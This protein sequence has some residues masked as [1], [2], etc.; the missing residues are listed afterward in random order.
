MIRTVLLLI[1]LV[2][3]FLVIFGKSPLP[4]DSFLIE[5]VVAVLFTVITTITAWFKN[6]YV[7]K[8]GMEQRK[9]LIERGL[10]KKGKHKRK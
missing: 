4:I 10:T 6:N 1:A 7:T 8:N 3:Q 5:N 9:I 2:N